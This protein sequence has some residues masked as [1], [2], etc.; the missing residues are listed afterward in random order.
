MDKENVEVIRITS[1]DDFME[2]YENEKLN[3][4]YI[5]END[6]SFF[7]DSIKPIGSSSNPFTGHFYGNGYTLSNFVIEGESATSLFMY[8]EGTIENLGLEKVKISSMYHATGFVY[9]N[10]GTIKNCYVKGLDI[11]TTGNYSYLSSFVYKNSGTITCCYANVEKYESSYV[12]AGFVAMNE[13]SGVIKDSFTV[14]DSFAESKIGAFSIINKGKTINVYTNKDSHYSN[15][16]FS[17][18]TINYVDSN[19]IDANFYSEKLQW[20]Q[21]TWDFEDKLPMLK[22]VDEND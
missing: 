13:E 4:I 16:D 10:S 11:S 14:F 9:E 1:Q 6:I 17:D 3:D 2:I 8:N 15:F 18:L 19:T 20:S 22:K 7:G 21:L 12:T 5:L